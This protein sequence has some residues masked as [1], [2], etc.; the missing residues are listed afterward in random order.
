MLASS[1]GVD[2]IEN[3]V[4]AQLSPPLF[5]ESGEAV[6]K[7]LLGVCRRELR[8]VLPQATAVCRCLGEA[9][10]KRVFWKLI[11]FVRNVVLVS[12]WDGSPVNC[13]LKIF[14]WRGADTSPPESMRICSCLLIQRAVCTAYRPLE[15]VRGGTCYQVVNAVFARTIPFVWV[16]IAFSYLASGGVRDIVHFVYRSN[17]KRNMQYLVAIEQISASTIGNFCFVSKFNQ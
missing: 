9:L 8:I 5:F 4:F 15:P 1:S 14:L 17:S 11:F 12:A 16:Y 7:T 10:V 3:R 2:S 6:R 13:R